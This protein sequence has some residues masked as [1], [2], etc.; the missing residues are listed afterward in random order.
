MFLLNTF[1]FVID[2]LCSYTF[3]IDSSVYNLSVILTFL[4]IKAS[5][6]SNLFIA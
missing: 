3:V 5:F 4:F 1:H 2:L 6:L